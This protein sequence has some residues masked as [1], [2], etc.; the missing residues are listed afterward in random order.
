M[1]SVDESNKPLGHGDEAA[2]PSSN[3]G[4][5]PTHELNSLVAPSVA[6][7]KR[8]RRQVF[9]PSLEKQYKLSRSK[10][11]LFEQCPRCFYLHVRCGISRPDSFPFSLNNEVDRRLK[12][13]FHEYR[14][15][16]EPHPYMVQHGLNAVPFKHE[17]ID[18]WQDSLRRGIQY[19]LPG[20]NL[21]I[22]GGIDD[23][24]ESRGERSGQLIIVDYKATSQQGSVSLDD[25]WKISYKRQA[26]IYQWLFK[27]N[28]FE[29]SDTAIFLFCNARKNGNTFNSRLDFEISL[30]PYQGNTDWVEK[31]IRE[32]FV[33]LQSNEKPA[34]S[35]CCEWCA[36]SEKIARL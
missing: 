14:R 9:D 12:E 23:V 4:T 8:S 1:A 24:W 6:T 21:I 5:A 35:S 30:L 19:A 20:T 25:P 2:G 15:R 31:T 13:E 11:E 3:M 28:G 17:Q 27:M 7:S 16:G 33:V 36:Y 18:A 10:I 22:T 32:A 29:V 26:E 34:P